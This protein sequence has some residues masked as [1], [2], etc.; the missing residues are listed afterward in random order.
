V[1]GGIER[2]LAAAASAAGDGGVAVMGGADVGR[3]FLRAGP[4]D[5]RSLHLLPVLFGGGTR[6]SERP[7][8]GH[9]R[10][11]R[12]GVIDAPAAVHRRF[13]VRGREP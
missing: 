10:L 5:E 7:G 1:I 13:R 11:E 3:Q 8:G 9:L 6:L 12:A 4:I 2:A